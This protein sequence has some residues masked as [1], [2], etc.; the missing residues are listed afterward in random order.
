MRSMSIAL[1]LVAGGL[2]LGAQ[3]GVRISPVLV[4]LTWAATRARMVT[5]SSRTVNVLTPEV[6]LLFGAN[7]WF[8]RVLL[9][10]TGFIPLQSI[11]RATDFA[12]QEIRPPHA[13]ATLLLS[14]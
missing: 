3:V 11:T 9:S 1:S 13:M 2:G 5:S 6:G 8:G 14:L 12:G 4:R 10:A 7:R